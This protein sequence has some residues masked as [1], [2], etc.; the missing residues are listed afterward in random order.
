MQKSL[1]EHS[2]EKKPVKSPQTSPRSPTDELARE[3]PTDPSNITGYFKLPHKHQVLVVYK[4]LFNM[5]LI[6]TL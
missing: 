3:S 5:L 4:N 2:N 1:K 6:R